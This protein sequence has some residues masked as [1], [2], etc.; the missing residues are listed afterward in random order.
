LAVTFVGGGNDARLLAD[1]E[2]L[3]KTKIELEAVE[4]DEDQPNIAKQGRINDGRRMYSQE[5]SS[6]PSGR[7]DGRTEG[8]GEGRSEGRGDGRAHSR[9]GRDEAPSSRGPRAGRNDY[10]RAPISRD[11]FF[12]KPYEAPV[13]ADANAPSWEATARPAARS[14]SANIKHKVKVAALFKSPS[15]EA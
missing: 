15:P 7:G 14:I 12:D 9:G 6:H 2:K 11:P 13:A 8:R 4:F 1:I 5:G 3:I 10:V